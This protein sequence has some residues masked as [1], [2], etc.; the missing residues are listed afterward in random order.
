M[1]SSPFQMVPIIAICFQLIIIRSSWLHNGNLNEPHT[2]TMTTSHSANGN[3]LT[4]P[5]VLDLRAVR[6]TPPAGSALYPTSPEFEFAAVDDKNDTVAP[7]PCEA[8]V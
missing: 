7:E 6:R 3:I 8:L 4:L 1:S 2:T 5:R